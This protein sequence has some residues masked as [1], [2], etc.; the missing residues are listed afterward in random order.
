MPGA[1]KF[2]SWAREN[3]RLVVWWANEISFSSLLVGKASTL[4]TYW[5]SNSLVGAGEDWSVLAHSLDNWISI[6]FSCPGF[7]NL[8]KK[9]FGHAGFFGKEENHRTWR[10]TLRKRR[11]LTK[12]SPHLWHWAGINPMP[13]RWEESALTTVLSLLS[14]RAIMLLCI[15]SACLQSFLAM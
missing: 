6:L 9:E 11:E 7:S 2:S 12:I 5:A 1:S 14:K 3:R 8:V 10:K 15:M 13:H 4:H